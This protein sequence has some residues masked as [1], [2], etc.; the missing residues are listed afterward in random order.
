MELEP[1]L[2]EDSADTG[3]VRLSDPLE[4]AETMELHRHRG[5]GDQIRQLPVYGECNLIAMMA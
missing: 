1:S 3:L 5:K 2:D 4:P